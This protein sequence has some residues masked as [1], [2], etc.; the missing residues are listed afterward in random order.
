MVRP[1]NSE[2]LNYTYLKG[3]FDFR[4]WTFINVH[5]SEPVGAFGLPLFFSLCEHNALNFNIFREKSVTINFKKN[6]EFSPKLFFVS[7][8]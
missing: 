5:F 8:Y 4:F 7:K 2:L 1:Y 6:D 3:I